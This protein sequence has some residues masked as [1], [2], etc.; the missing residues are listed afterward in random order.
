MQVLGAYAFLSLKKGKMAYLQYI[1][2]ALPALKD[3]LKRFNALKPSP[4][5]KLDNLTKISSK[6]E[7]K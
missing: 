3:L 4:H 5:F 7:V 6:L 2:F 1:P